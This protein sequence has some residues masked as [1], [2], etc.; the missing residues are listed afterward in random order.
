LNASQKALQEPRVNPLLVLSNTM[1]ELSSEADDFLYKSWV[2]FSKYII[3]EFSDDKDENKIDAIILDAEELA[4]RFEIDLNKRPPSIMLEAATLLYFILKSRGVLERY[5]ATLVK[6]VLDIISRECIEFYSSGSILLENSPLLS[7]C[8][9]LSYIFLD[10]LDGEQRRMLEEL[11]TYCNKLDSQH[12]YFC[13]YATFSNILRAIASKR[14]GNAICKQVTSLY[15]QVIKSATLENTAFTLLV[16]GLSRRLGCSTEELA[17]SLFQELAKKLEESKKALL[18]RN[19][20]T[21]QIITLALRLN[22]LEKLTYVPSG[23]IVMRE[24]T[25]KLMVDAVEGQHIRQSLM[26]TKASTVV[27]I[28]SLFLGIILSNILQLS[29]TTML[30]LIVLLLIATQYITFRLL[31]LETQRL[32]EVKEELRRQGLEK[33][34]R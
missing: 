9:G 13:M 33:V 16:I 22:K 15:K 18:R 20:V 5:R 12:L 11:V 27:S 2:L 32:N 7:K 19:R 25:F 6:P 14:E 1:G 3:Y 26:I 10:E 23:Y 31:T 24:E 17:L 4:Q 34:L 28:L 29:L 8:L 30:G 21:W